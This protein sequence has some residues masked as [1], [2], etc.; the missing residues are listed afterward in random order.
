MNTK[1]LF[2][3]IITAAF[4]LSLTQ[5][6]SN[7]NTKPIIAQFFGIW[8]NEGQVWEDKFRDDTPF[9]KLNRIHI[10]F[11]KI[12]KNNQ[13]QYTIDWDGDPKHAKAIIDRVKTDNREAEIFISL[14][15]PGAVFKSATNDP[16]FAQNVLNFLQSFGNDSD[17]KHIISGIDVDW[18]TDP[19]FSINTLVENLYK[20]L[21]PQGFKLTLDLMEKQPDYDIAVFANCLDQINLMSYGW[22]RCKFKDNYIMDDYVNLYIEAGFPKEKIIVGI[23]TEIGYPECPGDG[24]DTLGPEGSIVKKAEYCLENGLAGVMEWRLDND[25]AEKDNPHH[26]TY[27]GAHT[28]W[29]AMNKK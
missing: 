21:K 15:S 29:D 1:L 2:T 20:N 19:D 25:Y 9:K 7:L 4:C 27:Q 8:V 18:E 11:A 3:I 13:G 17:D 14:S 24:A 12:I 16:T 26:P 22:C 28:L 6:E 10:A 23:E 5:K